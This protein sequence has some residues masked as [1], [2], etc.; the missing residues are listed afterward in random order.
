M[1]EGTRRGLKLLAWILTMVLS[2]V[3]MYV[4]LGMPNITPT[5]AFRRTEHAGMMG[6]GDIL[7]CCAVESEHIDQLIVAK[8]E[9]NYELFTYSDDEWCDIGGHLCAYGLESGAQVFT[10]PWGFA[11]VNEAPLT[12]VLFDKECRAQAAELSWTKDGFT[13]TARSQREFSEFFL[14]E[15]WADSWREEE[16][17]DELGHTA[18][19]SGLPV[20]DSA[21]T[22]VVTVRLYDAS[23]ALLREEQVQVGN[24]RPA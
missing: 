5:M 17:L 20:G 18:G 7:A 16:A 1:R 15:F 14:L 13:Y 4:I 22:T 2:L 8:T 3:V 6:P 10:V 21:Q 9:Y 12:M 24:K 23:G 11:T 19:F